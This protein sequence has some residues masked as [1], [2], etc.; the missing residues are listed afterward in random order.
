MPSFKDLIIP[1]NITSANI[2]GIGHGGIL[3][4]SKELDIARRRMREVK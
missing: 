4:R 1:E 3:N 2:K